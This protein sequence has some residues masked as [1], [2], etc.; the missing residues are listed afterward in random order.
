MLLSLR[1]PNKSLIVLRKLDW[2][3]FPHYTG[4]RKGSL[5]HI[6]HTKTPFLHQLC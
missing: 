5:S 4:P 1:F 2:T 6:L 3:F